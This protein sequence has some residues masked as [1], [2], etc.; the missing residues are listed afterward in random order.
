ML[1]FPLIYSAVRGLRTE[2][3]LNASAL[4]VVVCKYLVQ[5]DLQ[6]QRLNEVASQIADRRLYINFLV[7]YFSLFCF[8]ILDL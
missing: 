3:E 7:P 2:Y 4:C 6:N 5:N 8:A 1:G